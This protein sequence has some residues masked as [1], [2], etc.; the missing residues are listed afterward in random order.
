VEPPATTQEI[1]NADLA[2]LHRLAVLG[3]EHAVLG[4]SDWR[5]MR[6]REI[7]EGLPAH[8][9]EHAGAFVTLK[10]GGKLR[11]CI[12]YILPRKPLYRAVLENGFNSACKDRRFV[13]V[14][15]DELDDLEVE[16]SVLSQPRPIGS[17]EEFLVGEQGVILHKDGRR[18]V[19]LPEVAV[20]QGWTRE[21][22]LTHL[23][24]KA[25]LPEDSWREGATFE[26][27]TSNKFVA[28]YAASGAENQ[29]SAGDEA[30][31]AAQEASGVHT[32]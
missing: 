8:L 16:V 15:P 31:G 28:P 3:V 30:L 26:V 7:V 1:G 27:F 23:A 32:Y 25:R 12:G 18:A 4:P 24:R 29:P 6:I 17:Y 20:E 9:Q 10:M 21:D 19:F 22:T 13:P 2:L 5:S 14:A 11:G